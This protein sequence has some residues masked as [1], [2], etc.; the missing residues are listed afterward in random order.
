ME[1][2]TPSKTGPFYPEDQ[3]PGFGANNAALSGVPIVLA[4]AGHTAINTIAAIDKAI[5][6]IPKAMR[7]ELSPDD[8]AALGA[9]VAL[10][11]G[12]RGAAARALSG[13]ADKAAFGVF[14]GPNSRTAD[15]KA[16]TAA[17]SME[18]AGADRNAIL[19]RTGWFKDVDGK[20]KYEISHA[21]AKLN[22]DKL[23]RTGQKAR[24]GE[25]Y[26]DPEL[27]A[28]Y[29][30]TR[31]IELNL[32]HDPQWEG[33]H[34]VRKTGESGINVRAPDVEMARSALIHELEHDLQAREGF[35]YGGNPSIIDRSLK[36]TGEQGWTKFQK[37]VAE[38]P[39]ISSLSEFMRITGETDA[40]SAEVQYK[41]WLSQYNDWLKATR[42]YVAGQVY[43]RLAGEV[44]ARN[45]Q[46][47][48]AIP[49][50]KLRETP[51]WKTA[52]VPEQERLM[53]S[54]YGEITPD[55]PGVALRA[56]SPGASV[57]PQTLGSPDASS[58]P[59][60]GVAGVS[61][62]PQA[63]GSPAFQQADAFT[64]G[65]E[66]S[67]I[68]EHD[69]GSVS[70]YGI[71]QRAY[72]N[73]DVRSL[74][75]DQAQRIRYK[76]WEAIHGDKL[77]SFDP[78]LATLAYDTAVMSGPNKA[79]DMLKA[80]GGDPFAFLNLRVEH[81]QR[82]ARTPIHQK[83]AAGWMNRNR[84]LAR[85]IGA[86]P[87]LV[88]GAGGA[89]QLG[90]DAEPR[91]LTITP[92]GSGLP[93]LPEQPMMYPTPA[94]PETSEAPKPEPANKPPLLAP[95][96]PGAL[97]TTNPLEPRVQPLEHD[98]AKPVVKSQADLYRELLDKSGAPDGKIP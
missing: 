82:L 96:N 36:D 85:S 2:Q 66:G 89:S 15:L 10:L 59:V 48:A 91:P 53:G 80:S 22:V 1:P 77:N 18:R 12:G 42:R 61:A 51:P 6:D 63:I 8:M 40:A 31:D 13:P 88:G 23:T 64:H 68:N 33:G 39:P 37:Q 3:F 25:V 45:A 71:H 16:L 38:H 78:R 46:A 94:P 14:A 41:Q 83:D 62:A 72:P 52:D 79:I 27:Y 26:E 44:N 97:I 4:V 24:L 87:D 81:Q 47:R 30:E 35:A 60:S 67:K 74:T 76:Y 73:I 20:W 84:D 90:G 56:G 98:L 57:A 7:G 29:P 92:R 54:R 69:T 50:D 9:N 95:G 28:A 93:A 43:K 11:L 86:S 75:A 49:K 65:H 34:F 21:Q 17:Q 70:R 55:K 32:R 5:E 19:S 58:T